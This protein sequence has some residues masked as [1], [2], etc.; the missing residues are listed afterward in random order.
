SEIL[1]RLNLHSRSY[2]VMT[3]HRAVN[4]DDEIRLKQLLKF[5]DNVEV[6]KIIFPVHPRTKRILSKI[7]IPKKIITIEPIGDIDMVK[8]TKESLLVLTDSGG[9]QKE[10][11]W[12]SVPCIT[13]REET[14][15]LE[16]VELGWNVLYKD[17]K[18]IESFAKKTAYPF[19]DGRAGKRIAQVISDM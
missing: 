13:L 1:T 6:E 4:V 17:Y 11:F 19:G 15:W 14:E 9:L 7:E 12:L 2:A 5:V 18:G 3:M 8:L 10:A 16:T